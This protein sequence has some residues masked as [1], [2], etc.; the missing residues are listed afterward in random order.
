MKG[1]NSLNLIMLKGIKETCIYSENLESLKKFYHGQLGL[2]IIDYS[3]GRHIF[4]RVGYSVLLAFN[5]EDS[6][7]KKSPPAHFGHGPAHYAFEVDPLE[8]LEWKNKIKDL[9]IE[10]IDE[11]IWKNGMESF[12]F[13]DP[14]GHILEIV[15]AGVWDNF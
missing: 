8:Y 10:I 2:E 1:Q 9:G 14:D 6:K 4:F 11:L 12:Y 5:P 13:K 7:L 3:P 15:P